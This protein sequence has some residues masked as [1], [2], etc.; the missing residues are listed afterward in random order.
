MGSDKR[1]EMIGIE[2]I[3]IPD[4]DKII[5]DAPDGISYSHHECGFQL[6]NNVLKIKYEIPFMG[7]TD[8]FFLWFM[9]TTPKIRISGSFTSIDSDS[10]DLICNNLTAHTGDTSSFGFSLGGGT[11]DTYIITRNPTSP[12]EK[13]GPSEYFDKGT[14]LMK[15]A[16]KKYNLNE[17]Y[18]IYEK[19]SP[20]KMIENMGKGNTGIITQIRKYLPL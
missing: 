8:D 13:T 15:K 5:E 3:F 11:L 19:G 18:K 4:L 9:Q 20:Q 7:G 2:K 17:W 12:G 6:E 14:E 1:N 10:Y 16:A